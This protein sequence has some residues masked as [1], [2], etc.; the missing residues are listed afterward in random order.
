MD[1]ET[2]DPAKLRQAAQRFHDEVGGALTKAAAAFTGGTGA[3]AIE[4][5][6]FTSVATALALIYVEATNFAGRDI[7]TKLGVARQFNDLLADTANKWD[8]AE[9]ASTIPRSPG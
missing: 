7:Q 8:S 9:H 6:N 1:E 4:Y 3:T 5:S 2:I